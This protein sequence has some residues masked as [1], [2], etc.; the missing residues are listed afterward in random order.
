MKVSFKLSDADRERYGGDEWVHVDTNRLADLGYDRLSELERDMKR[1]DDTSIVRIIGPEWR[2]MSMLGVRGM[3]W[4]ARQ[5][6]GSEKPA[7]PDFKPDALNMTFKLDAGD[8]ADPPAD[9]SLEPPSAKTA[10]AKSA[11]SKKA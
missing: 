10:T 3:A 9:G 6:S 2:N 7:W 8:D 5:V 1:Y 11:R 4:L